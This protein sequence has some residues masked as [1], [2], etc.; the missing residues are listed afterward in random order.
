MANISSTHDRVLNFLPA[1]LF[2][3]GKILEQLKLINITEIYN[4]IDIIYIDKNGKG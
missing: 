3:M 2:K 1:F 4:Y